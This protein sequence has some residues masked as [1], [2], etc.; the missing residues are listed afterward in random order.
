M[1]TYVIRKIRVMFGVLVY[2]HLYVA[3]S[4]YDTEPA[5]PAMHTH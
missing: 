1:C 2:M 4:F 3:V 5:C